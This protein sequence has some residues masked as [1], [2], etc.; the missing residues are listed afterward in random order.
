MVLPQYR[1]HKYK[2]QGDMG[3]LKFYKEH[4]RDDAKILAVAVLSKYRIP[5]RR[6]DADCRTLSGSDR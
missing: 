2:I 6:F 1:R 5:G 4:K 3:I